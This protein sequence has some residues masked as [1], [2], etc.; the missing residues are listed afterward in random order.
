VGALWGFRG[1]EELLKDGAQ[2]LINKP[3]EVLDL[4]GPDGHRS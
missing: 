2:L 4:L 3:S 1:K